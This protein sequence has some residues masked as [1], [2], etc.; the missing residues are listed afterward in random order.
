MRKPVAGPVA[1]APHPILTLQRTIGNRAVARAIT[2]GRIPATAATLQRESVDELA[3]SANPWLSPPAT[4]QFTE[5]YAEL[6]KLMAAMHQ[7]SSLSHVPAMHSVAGLSD[8]VAREITARGRIEERVQ[9]FSAIVSSMSVGVEAVKLEL[10]ASDQQHTSSGANQ[11]TDAG[12][13]ARKSLEVLKQPPP[14][15]AADPRAFLQ[16]QK[17]QIKALLTIVEELVKASKSA[18]SQGAGAPSPLADAAST[19]P[20]STTAGSNPS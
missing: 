19:A 4:T 18:S 1:A 13:L 14:V 9:L 6:A 5:N 16:A 20:S 3:A 8:D 2:E 7:L 12:E 10:P 17:L 11:V 15:S